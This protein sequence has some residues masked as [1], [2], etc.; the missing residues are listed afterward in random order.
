ML[1]YSAI[2]TGNGMTKRHA[3]LCNLEKN[4]RAPEAFEVIPK[5]STFYMISYMLFN[6]VLRE[7]ERKK[8]PVEVPSCACG[9][10]AAALLLLTVAVRHKVG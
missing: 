10:T 6:G 2:E 9:C 1:A 7:R 3:V 5:E 4:S 8:H